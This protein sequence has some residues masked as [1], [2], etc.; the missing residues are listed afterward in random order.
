MTGTFYDR[1]FNVSFS[2]TYLFVPNNE[3][4]C[5]IY[6][7]SGDYRDVSCGERDAALYI[8]SSVNIKNRV[9][10]SHF[11]ELRGNY[12][13]ND[14][15]QNAWNAHGDSAFT[16][17]VLEKCSKT[18]LLKREQ[19]W[20][21]FY[22]ASCGERVLY[23]TCPEAGK[24]HM[25]EEDRYKASLRGKERWSGKGNPMAGSE[26]FGDKNPFHG[27]KHSAETKAKLSAIAKERF[28]DKANHPLTGRKK[29]VAEKEYLRKIHL[30][31]HHSPESKAK[32]SA[33]NK[34]KPNIKNR[35]PPVKQIDIKNGDIIKIW[36]C[37]SE[38]AK[39]LNIDESC[40]SRCADGRRDTKGA[41]CLSVGGFKWARVTEQEQKANA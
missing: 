31:T 14:K 22:K 11:P 18:E 41:R 2:G 35:R 10:C 32:L 39:A 24:P 13:G 20:I 27:K 25:S 17:F 34:G 40:I 33:A 15:L 5:G 12:H 1:T 7:I 26:R 36:D 8:G 30:G 21:D 6:A 38:A 9:M 29:T 4:I 19:N 16:V 3:K 23:N 37:C 28:K